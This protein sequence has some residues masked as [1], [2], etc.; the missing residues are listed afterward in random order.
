M[1]PRKLGNAEIALAM[2]LRVAGIRLNQIARGLS[3]TPDWLA[4]RIKK[5]KREGM[6]K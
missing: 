2:E 1:Y 4:E 5:A 6:I 3:V